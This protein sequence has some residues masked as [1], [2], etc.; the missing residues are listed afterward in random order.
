VGGRLSDRYG[1]RHNILLLAGV[2]TVGTLGCT[3]SPTWEVL[4]FFRFVLG[5][6]VGGA[7]ATVPVYLAEVSPYERRGSLSP[8]TR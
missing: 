2:F 8:A 4:A 1:R 7:S 6:A 5:L 3:L